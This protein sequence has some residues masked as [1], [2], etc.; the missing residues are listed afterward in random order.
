MATVHWP[1]ISPKLPTLT[2]ENIFVVIEPLRCQGLL[3][4]QSFRII[5]NERTQGL[6]REQRAEMKRI[7]RAHIFML[8]GNNTLTLNH[9]YLYVHTHSARTPSIRSR[10]KADKKELVFQSV[11]CCFCSSRLEFQSPFFL[12]VSVYPPQLHTPRMH[13]SQD[14][15]R[16]SSCCCFASRVHTRRINLTSPSLSAVL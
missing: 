15:T 9:K 6:K 4:D 7:Y 12:F 10:T 16:E 1:P 5:C 14:S 8:G 2:V 3:V 11:G 13:R